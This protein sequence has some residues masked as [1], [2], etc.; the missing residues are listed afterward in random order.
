MKKKKA[1]SDKQNLKNI[2][3]IEWKKIKEKDF[4][5][6]VVNPR[7]LLISFVFLHFLRYQT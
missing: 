3:I 4:F 2:I 1:M 6:L 5:F 7:F